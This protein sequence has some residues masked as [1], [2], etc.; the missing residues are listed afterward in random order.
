LLACLLSA[1]MILRFG[2]LTSFSVVVGLSQPDALI[3][4]TNHGEIVLDPRVYPY[5]R[6]KYW[7]GVPR[8]RARPLYVDVIIRRY[9][10]ETGAAVLLA[11]SGETFE[12]VAARRRNDESDG[13][14]TG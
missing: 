6:R 5:R 14:P 9:E 4:L 10:A 7:A 13:R 12:K 2:R 1:W 8:H 3:D 11:E